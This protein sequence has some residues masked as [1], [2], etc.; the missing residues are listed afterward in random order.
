MTEGKDAFITVLVKCPICAR[1]ARHRY[2]KSKLYTPVEVENDMHVVRYR[3]ESP[4]YEN[5]HPSYYYIWHCPHCHF[6]DEREV[7]RGKDDSKGK[8]ELIQDKILVAQRTSSSV[9]SKL[10]KMIDLSHEFLSLQSALNAHILATYIQEILSPNNRQYDKLAKFYLR[11][12][13]LYREQKHL[14]E[15]APPPPTGYATWEAFHESLKDQWPN[16][17]VNETE[18]LRKAVECYQEQLNR[19]GQLSDIKRDLTIMF[20]LVNLYLRLEEIDE[21]HKHVR[22]AFTL[23]TRQR[24]TTRKI[25]DEGVHSGRLTQQQIEPMRNLIQWLNNTIERAADMAD[26]INDLIFKEEYPRAREIILAMGSPTPEDI[27]K[28]LHEDTFHEV[29]VRRISAMF[30]KKKKGRGGSGAS[31]S[32]SSASSHMPEGDALNQ[33]AQENQEK[34]AGGVWGWIQNKTQDNG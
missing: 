18:A 26:H 29:T 28:R 20:L 6:C 34:K 25:L 2:V 7:F 12:A 21:A 3:W 19:A 24:Q 11:I 31:S 17:P 23:A 27:V 13:W 16:L 22:H 10:G 33:K 9:L 30:E 32:S 15:P 5:I 4:E 14:S 8:L 1:D